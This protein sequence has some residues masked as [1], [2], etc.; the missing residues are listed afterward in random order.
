MHKE[1]KN[2][3]NEETLK[4]DLKETSKKDDEQIDEK[5]EVNEDE[6]DKVEIT[7][8]EIE[9]MNKKINDSKELYLRAQA[10]LVN[11]RK[12]KDEE[13]SRTLKYCN[14]NL[15]SEILPVIDN[16]ERALSQESSDQKLLDGINMVYG[17]LKS[18]LLNYGLQEMD[19]LDKPFDPN[20]HQAVT[21]ESVSDKD[22]DIVLEVLQKGYMF[23]DKILRPAMVKVNKIER[24]DK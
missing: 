3:Q 4:K 6:I 20:F 5:E 2:N 12:R 9:A 14:E 17:S 18:I 22:D 1:N 10:E 21:T 23:K 7:K 8:E 16:F 11:Y 15:I 19:C 13:I 24:N